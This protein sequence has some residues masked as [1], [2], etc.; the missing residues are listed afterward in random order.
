MIFTPSPVTPS[1]FLGLPPPSE[2]D[3]LYG[4]PLCRRVRERSSNFRPIV[5]YSG[6]FVLLSRLDLKPI[7][8]VKTG[9][10][11]RIRLDSTSE[12]QVDFP[13]RLPGLLWGRAHR[14]VIS[15]FSWGGPKIF[16]I[17]QCHRTI[18]KLENNSTLYIVN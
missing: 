3:I 1:H 18:E 10:G 11:K 5:G 9:G 16:F 14:G 17:F 2:H 7:A 13:S 4:R 8:L 15:T 6:Q 12:V